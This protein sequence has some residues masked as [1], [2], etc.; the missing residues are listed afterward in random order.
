MTSSE[1]G[2]NSASAAATN[3]PAASMSVRSTVTTAARPP[4]PAIRAASSSASLREALAWIATA[5]PCAARSSTIALPIRLAPP[6]TSA[7]PAA[8]IIACPLFAAGAILTAPGNV[9]FFPAAALW[10]NSQIVGLIQGQPVGRHLNIGRDN[11]LHQAGL[12]AKESHL[13]TCL[14]QIGNAILPPY[15]RREKTSIQVRF[16]RISSPDSGTDERRAR[17]LP[18]GVRSFM[19][20]KP[21]SV[22]QGE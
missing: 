7:V 18:G 12:S 6:V 8:S 22:A 20:S 5:K 19:M 15:L 21:V 4:A 1:T 3:A 14:L 2:P 11:P 16:S 13:L 10:R 17:F 9:L